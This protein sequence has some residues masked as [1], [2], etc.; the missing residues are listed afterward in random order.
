MN[1]DPSEEIYRIMDK[2]GLDTGTFLDG[3]KG[4]SQIISAV[5]M[6]LHDELVKY[7]QQREEQHDR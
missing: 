6:K 5:R 1:K 4:M 7:I 2:A 3:K